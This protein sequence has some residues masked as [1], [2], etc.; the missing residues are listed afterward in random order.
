MIDFRLGNLYGLT[1]ELEKALSSYDIALTYCDQD[2]GLWQN[3]GKTA[4]DL[5]QYGVAAESFLR[6]YELNSK[7]EPT[8]LFYTAV[9][10]MYADQKEVAL[11]VL[12]KLL[13]DTADSAQDEWLETYT[14]LCIE[15]KQADR[16]LEHLSRWH[17][18]FESRQ[19]FWRLQALVHIQ[20]HEYEK[21]AANLKVLAAFGSL[22]TAD[23]KLLADLLLQINIPLEAVKLY[24]ELLTQKPDDHQLYEK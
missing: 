1:G 2:T 12:E 14:N 20:L 22:K 23:K 13:A 4:W 10:W 9:A 11:G 6:A 8:L 5:K 7:K 17:T 19:T 16:A 15:Q 18:Y 3:Q 24:E 21:G